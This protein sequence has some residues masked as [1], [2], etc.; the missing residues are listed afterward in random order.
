[1]CVFQG[2]AMERDECGGVVQRKRHRG[3]EQQ[4]EMP[5]AT[6]LIITTAELA[7]GACLLAGLLER[8]YTALGICEVC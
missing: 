4:V 6:R 7:V 2:S 3:R 5:S 1:M 8:R